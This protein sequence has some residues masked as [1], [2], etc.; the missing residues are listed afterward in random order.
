[1]EK[2]LGAV[3]KINHKVMRKIKEYVSY[4]E[5]NP[6]RVIDEGDEEAWK[7]VVFEQKDKRIFNL[8]GTDIYITM[9]IDITLLGKMKHLSIAI[10]H[11]NQVVEP[12][13]AMYIAVLFGFEV[14]PP[15]YTML[16]VKEMPNNYAA[17]HVIEPHFADSPKTNT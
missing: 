16:F 6:V 7:K 11:P 12:D 5:A 2:K 1:M 9:S 17:V 14:K 15:P 13:A 3:L 4:I 8:P 10:H